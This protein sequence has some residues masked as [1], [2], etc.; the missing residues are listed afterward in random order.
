MLLDQTKRKELENLGKL[1][2]YTEIR[3]NRTKKQQVETW[4]ATINHDPLLRTIL[5]LV[6]LSDPAN[7]SRYR[8]PR[9]CEP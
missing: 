6:F 2:E 9:S 8:N 1:E 4:F 5:I 7:S 3:I